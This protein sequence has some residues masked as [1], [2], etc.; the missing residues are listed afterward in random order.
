MPAPFHD[1]SHVVD[2]GAA[3]EVVGVAADTV[4]ASVP[5]HRRPGLGGEVVGDAV[6]GTVFAVDVELAVAV[7]SAGALPFPTGVGVGDENF[8]P[9][10]LCV[11][12]QDH[13]APTVFRLWRT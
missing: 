10:A 8:L 3:F 4:V 9:E 7:A 6:G 12:V 5:Y 2:L 11:A 1:V 13:V